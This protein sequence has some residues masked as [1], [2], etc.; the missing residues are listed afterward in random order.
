MLVVDIK[1]TELSLRAKIAVS[2]GD[3][4]ESDF[5]DAFGGYTHIRSLIVGDLIYSVTPKMLQGFIMDEFE[6]PAVQISHEEYNGSIIE[7]ENN[8]YERE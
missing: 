5:Y 8:L 3:S 4:R 1:E 2:E 7:N 6:N